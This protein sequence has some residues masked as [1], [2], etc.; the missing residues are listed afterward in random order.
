VHIPQNY[1]PSN[2]PK[3]KV[4]YTFDARNET[5]LSIKEGDVIVVV[6]K[7]GSG[8]NGGELN[9]KFGLYPANYAIQIHKKISLALDKVQPKILEI[10][11]QLDLSRKLGENGTVEEKHNTQQAAIVT[12]EVPITADGNSDEFETF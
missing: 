10:Q 9:G 1:N 11:Q 3:A 8:W 5:E 12:E 4:V 2:Y 7:R 6:E